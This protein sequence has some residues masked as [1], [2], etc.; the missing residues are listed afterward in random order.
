[1]TEAG[2]APLIILTLAYLISAGT[3]LVGLFLQMTGQHKVYMKLNIFFGL[4]NVVLNII[5]VMRFG[6]L[7]AAMATAFCIASLEVICTCIIY[8]RFSILSLAKGFKFDIIL[9]VIV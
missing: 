8:K 5:L 4:L 6:I 2:Y 3:G 1:M 9:I 7:G